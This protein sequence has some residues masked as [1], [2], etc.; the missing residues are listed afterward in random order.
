METL[1][2]L[3]YATVTGDLSASCASI[4]GISLIISLASQTPY[5]SRL[6]FPDS[7]QQWCHLQKSESGKHATIVML[8]IRFL[9][10]LIFGILLCM[11]ELL[12]KLLFVLYVHVKSH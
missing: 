7:W 5:T 12:L 8:Y 3:V 6:L 9:I 10:S 11:V 4:L 1:L 2:V